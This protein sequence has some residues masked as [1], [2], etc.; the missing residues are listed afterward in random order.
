VL[1]PNDDSVKEKLL[2]R[3]VPPHVIQGGG[4]ALIAGWRRFVAEVEQGYPLCLDDYR[5][6]LDLREL[7]SVTGLDSYVAADDERLRQALIPARR[8]VW[9]TDVPD[10][11]WVRGYPR[12][13]SGELLA[14]LKA[15]GLT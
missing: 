6:D 14:D 2:A 7:I 8:P 15:E 13:A 5:N 4:E 3:G 1:R 11:F 12:N 10:A 9:E